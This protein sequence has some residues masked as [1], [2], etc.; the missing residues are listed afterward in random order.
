RMFAGTSGAAVR[1]AVRFTDRGTR[2]AKES[3]DPSF[4]IAS[5]SCGRPESGR[6]AT[7]GRSTDLR[8][9]QGCN[10]YSQWNGTR[11]W[12]GTAGHAPGRRLVNFAPGGA[13]RDHR[14]PQSGLRLSIL[15][16]LLKLE[17]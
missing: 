3:R 16:C 13:I 7:I 15:L 6:H 17:E 5:A 14:Q 11:V 4:I 8:Q 10:D 9:P 2:A 12:F 1:P